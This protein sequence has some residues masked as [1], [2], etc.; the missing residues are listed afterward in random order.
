MTRFATLASSPDSTAWPGYR[1][2]TV[3][4]RRMLLGLGAAG[5]STFAQLYAPQGLLPTLPRY[6]P[7]DRWVSRLTADFVDFVDIHNTFLRALNGTVRD[8][9]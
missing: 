4:Y 8:G 7:G 2:G 3:A 6:V 5:I 9:L 1:A